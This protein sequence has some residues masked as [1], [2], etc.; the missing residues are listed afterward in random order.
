MVCDVRDGFIATSYE[1]VI[2]NTRVLLCRYL[3]CSAQVRVL[4]NPANA[5]AALLAGGTRCGDAAVLLLFA[6]RG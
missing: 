5:E 3:C 6:G 1:L 2:A 4:F